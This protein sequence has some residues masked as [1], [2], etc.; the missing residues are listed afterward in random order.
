MRFRLAAAVLAAALAGLAA[1]SAAAADGNPLGAV[2]GGSGIVGPNDVRYTAIWD[3]LTTV[4]LATSTDDGTAYNSVTL[5]GSWGVPILGWNGLAGGLGHD[6]RTLVLADTG[7]GQPLKRRS[8]FAV[9]DVK[10]FRLLQEI[11]L[12]GDF[13]FDALS[14]SGRMLFLIQH[15]DRSDTTHYVVRAYDRWRLR[16]LPG[17]IADRTQKSWV[18]QGYPL[19]RTTSADGRWVYTLYTNPGGT[20]FVHALDTVGMKAHC[21]GVPWPS[22]NQDALA[23]MTLALHG[24]GLALSRRGGARYLSIDTRSWRVSLAQPGFPWWTL[25]AGLGG[26]LAVVLAVGAV[27]VRLRGRVARRRT[28]PRL[29]VS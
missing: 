23:T 13:A 20:P 19:T 8:S 6:G 2:Q 14:P 27:A 11:R 3:G 22:K 29:A 17:R 10:R 25:A 21:V 16:L 28:G 4:L 26:A 5:G 7:A 18:M 9:L 1:A 12:R 24:D 15:V